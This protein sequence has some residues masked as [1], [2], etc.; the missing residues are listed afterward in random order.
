MGTEDND[1]KN[2]AVEKIKNLQPPDMIKQAE[3]F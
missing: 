2:E 1:N 3:N